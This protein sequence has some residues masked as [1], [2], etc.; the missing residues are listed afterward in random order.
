MQPQRVGV[1]E[2]GDGAPAAFDLGSAHAF[3]GPV[4]ARALP[5]VAVADGGALRDAELTHGPVAQERHAELIARARDAGALRAQRE[6]E[7]RAHLPERR[8][9]QVERI[10]AV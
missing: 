9:A 1:D 8:G 3:E 5:C 7:L 4:A 6:L 2:G 10:A